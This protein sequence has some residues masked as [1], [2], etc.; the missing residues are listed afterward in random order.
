[1]QFG[2]PYFIDFTTSLPLKET[3]LVLWK[4]IEG[5]GQE[6][7]MILIILFKD[8]NSLKREPKEDR[9]TNQEATTTF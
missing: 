7:K 4:L 6:G 3:E 8:V 5:C 1:M 9:E 2:S